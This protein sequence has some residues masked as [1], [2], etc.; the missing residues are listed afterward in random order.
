MVLRAE[1]PDRF[2]EVAPVA[3]AHSAE[4]NLAEAVAGLEVA[5]SP[6]ARLAAPRDRHLLRWFERER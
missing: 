3:E 5:P 1:T 4:A 2:E 6:W